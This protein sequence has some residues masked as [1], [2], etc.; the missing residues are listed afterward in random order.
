MLFPLGWIVFSVASWRAKV[1]SRGAS[2]LVIVGVLLIPF[3]PIVAN[4]LL[5]AGWGWMGYSIWA[6]AGAGEAG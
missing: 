2:V 1:Y 4:L 5:G 3:L 6:T